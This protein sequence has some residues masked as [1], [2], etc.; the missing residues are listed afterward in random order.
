MRARDNDA[1]IAAVQAVAWRRLGPA[2]RL[3]VAAEMSDDTRRVAAEKIRKSNPSYSED[4]VR[5]A[6]S[7]AF[8]DNDETPSDR[9]IAA[10][11]IALEDAL[12]RLLSLLESSHVP[13]MLTGSIASTA[14]GVPRATTDLDVVI[15]PS[16][17]ELDAL[18]L[19]L[20]EG[21][22]RIDGGQARAR[23]EV[24]RRSHFVV[25]D[26][27]TSWKVDLVIRKERPFSIAEFERRER[28]EVLGVP[29]WVASAEDIIVSK[30][31]WSKQ[32][33]DITQ[34]S[35][36]RRD[37]AGVVASRGAELDRTYVEHWVE[38]LDLADEWRQ[39]AIVTP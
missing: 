7:K 13:F 36:Q 32:A 3:R 37:V 31:E 26:D 27:A 23:R 29:A 9:R 14:H 21:G 6:L 35:R 25:V 4:E 8:G 39:A 18:L 24:V 30:L 38:A 16:A 20:T 10:T 22:W 34:R 11:S 12:A 19:A 2:G 33:T 28:V 17:P 5:R 1:K 15:D